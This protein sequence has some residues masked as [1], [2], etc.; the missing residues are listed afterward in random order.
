M[1][2]TKT[3]EKKAPV[4]EPLPQEI[5]ESTDLLT[6]EA[7]MK[8]A[9]AGDEPT[10]PE[11]EDPTAELPRGVFYEGAW[12]THVE[13][14][15]LNGMDEERLSKYK[16]E[17]DLFN[18]I[19]ALGTERIGSIDFSGM[20]LAERE[21]ILDNLLVGERM[22]LF[23]TVVAATFGDERPV[24]WICNECE[25]KNVTDL[26]LS[27]DFKPKIPE[28]VQGPFFFTDSKGREIEFR[29]V[30]GA[31]VKNISTGMNMGAKNTT[32]LSEI[33]LKLDGDHIID[34]KDFVQHL[35][36]KDRRALLTKISEVQPEVSLSVEVPC[37]S[38]GKENTLALSWVELFL[39]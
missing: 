23:L 5:D 27:E 33:L 16:V 8:K 21:S 11:A 19:L 15:E 32:V 14:R 2:A 30:T 36:M 35:G 9:L 22:I 13:V 6:D 17:E 28:D 10:M 37:H 24:E 26:V 25:S 4:R 34:K 18:A 31:D 7:A 3:I 20:S 39:T 38:C 29:P 12:Q 1:T